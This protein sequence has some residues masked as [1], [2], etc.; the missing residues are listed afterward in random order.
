MPAGWGAIDI[1]VLV[2]IG[3]L[4]LIARFGGFG[5]GLWPPR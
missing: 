1:P 2:G 5:R 4:I 3:I